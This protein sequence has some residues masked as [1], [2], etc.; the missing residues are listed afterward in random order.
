MQPFSNIRVIDLSHVIAGPF[1]TYQ[2]G[3]MGADVI[4]VK[5][6][7]N[8]DILR[9]KTDEFPDGEKDLGA[10]FTSQNAKKRSISIDLKSK[11]GQKIVSQL[12][13]TADLASKT[14]TQEQ[15]LS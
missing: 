12:I 6:P 13:A 1:C 4:R 8:P 5:A 15:W 11:Q 2:L 9:A 3:V 14:T 7:T 10:F